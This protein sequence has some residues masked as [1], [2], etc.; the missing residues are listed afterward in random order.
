MNRQILNGEWKLYICENVSCAAFADKITTETE[1]VR[2]GIPFISGTVPGNFELDMFKNGLIKDPFYGMNILEMQKLENRHLWYAH[3][4][5]YESD[6]YESI[7][8]AFEGIDTFSD[9]YLNGNKIGS[10]DNMFI[11]HEFPATSITKGKNELIVHIKPTMIEARNYDFAM[12]SLYHMKYNSA[13]MSV[14]KAA[15]S[16]GWD[17]APR[18]ISGGI[19]RNVSLYQ[20]KKDRIEELY[21][22]TASLN[23]DWASIGGFYS[24][25]MCGD[26]STDYS[27]KI[28]G[29][30]GEKSFSHTI[31][32]LWHNRSVFTF[33]ID[34]PLLWWPRDMGPQNLYKVSAE[35]LYL[36]KTVDVKEFNFGI[37]TIELLRSEITNDAGNGEFCFKVNGNKFFARGTNWVPLD[38]FHSRD[39]QR[40]D[41]AL[42]MVLDINCNMIRCWGG[43][44]YEDKPFFDFCDKNGILV[45]QDFAMGCAVYPQDDDFANRLSIE[46]EHIVKKLRQH[47][48]LAIWAGDNECDLA[49]AYWSIKPHRA[50]GLNR[51]TREVIPRIIQKD[52]P[53]RVYLPS[54]PYIGQECFENGSEHFAPENHLWGPRDY[55]KG[56]FYTKSPAHFAS[57][58][59]Y[60]GCPAVN[61]LKKFISPD[62]LWPWDNN[63]WQVHSTCMETGNNVPYAFRNPLMASQVKVLFGIEPDN[64]EDFVMASQFSQGEALKFFIERFRMGKWNRTGII[65]WNL[66]D[67]WPQISDSVVD[68]YYEKK[69][70]YYYIKRS[71]EPVALMMSEPNYNYLTLIGANE[72]LIDKEVNYCVKEITNNEEVFSGKAVIPANGI[73]EIE[74][75]QYDENAVKF[76]LIEWQCDGNSYKNHYISGKPPFSLKEYCEYMKTSG[77]I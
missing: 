64:I 76:Y 13:S 55:Y 30:C 25:D 57:E 15:H 75:I 34:K 23:D 31:D 39:A 24:I 17:I 58:T 32:K 53:W 46:V 48:S 59:G 14:R 7:F 74:R 45:W 1:L 38:A 72:F 60:H 10:T 68:Y 20:K 67:C 9:I 54:S 65:W 70:S 51:L 11:T 2:N 73:C 22:Q 3:N 49:S 52:D 61:S 33:R 4:F 43:N 26:F 5:E 16:F 6:D 27:L 50:P 42:E 69:L 56:E 36:G 40:L 28:T 41:H 77:L 47:P 66:I 8:L 12:D 29:I 63:E 71:Q 35:L 37:R 21:L 18:I 19:W 62:K 44:V